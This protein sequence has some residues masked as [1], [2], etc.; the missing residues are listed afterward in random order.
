M[1]H[2]LGY[3]LFE[4]GGETYTSMPPHILYSDDEL[5]KSK[6]LDISELTITS[7]LTEF[8]SLSILRKSYGPTFQDNV[9]GF[10][11]VIFESDDEWFY[12]MI[13]VGHGNQKSHYGYKCDQLEGV[14][15]CIRHIYSSFGK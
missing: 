8:P 4:S 9:Y 2:L 14:F 6:T 5:G 13:Y 12:L 3:K 1:K 10:N 7:I 15:D 11:I